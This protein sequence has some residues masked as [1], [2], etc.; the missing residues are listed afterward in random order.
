V[1]PAHR[2][3]CLEAAAVVACLRL[4]RCG[5]SR[6]K[7]CVPQLQ[8][9]TCVGHTKRS[10]MSAYSKSVTVVEESNY[11]T[12]AGAMTCL[13]TGLRRK[14]DV[15]GIPGRTFIVQIK[16]SR[17][18]RTLVL[19]CLAILVLGLCHIVGLYKGRSLT[20]RFSKYMYLIWAIPLCSSK[21]MYFTV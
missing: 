11:L 1:H 19:Y 16:F 10:L 17:K 12:G 18:Q 3:G 6:R 14:A 21:Y 5:D 2:T 4:E 20:N 8:Q 9:R 15:P 13:A 7:E